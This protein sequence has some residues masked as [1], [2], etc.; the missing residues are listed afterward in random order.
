VFRK[1][2]SIDPALYS[3]TDSLQLGP[4]T[5]PR[6]RLPFKL[7][8]SNKGYQMILK[9]GWEEGKG[10]VQRAGQSPT[11]LPTS[12]GGTPTWGWGAC[13]IRTSSP[14]R[15]LRMRSGYAHLLHTL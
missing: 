12:V 4:A 14:A 8:Y 1:A 15:V 3:H 11:F 13:G 2:G 6:N 10:M 7:H 5:N 9:Q